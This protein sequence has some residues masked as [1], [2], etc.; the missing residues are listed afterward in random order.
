M[1]GDTVTVGDAVAL[2]EGVTLVGLGGGTVV[3]VL[4]T[5]ALVSV[6][7][8][9]RTLQKQAVPWVSSV[10]GVYVVLGELLTSARRVVKLESLL[11]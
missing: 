4:V 1:D 2:T 3:N 10:V 7:N 11:S 6:P 8:L 9:D 5:Q